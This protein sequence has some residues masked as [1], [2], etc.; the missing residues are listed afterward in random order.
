MSTKFQV[1]FN[2]EKNQTNRIKKVTC[3]RVLNLRGKTSLHGIYRRDYTL[4]SILRSPSIS[5]A[6][7]DSDAM[8]RREMDR[9]E[10]EEE[11]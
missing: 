2:H 1:D 4:R 7:A 8:I 6:W 10:G 11:T 3:G 9:R 5:H